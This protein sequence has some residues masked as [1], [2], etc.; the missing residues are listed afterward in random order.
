M[1][2]VYHNESGWIVTYPKRA[3]YRCGF[4][5]PNSILVVGRGPT[6]P[7][8]PDST[9]DQVF[10]VTKLGTEMPLTAVPIKW[11]EPLGLPGGR[12][13]KQAVKPSLAISRQDAWEEKMFNFK[14]LEN[15]FYAKVLVCG[16][17]AGCVGFVIDIVWRSL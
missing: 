2:H 3:I 15:E 1:S 17:L 6:T 11:R 12:K 16:F 10:D 13:L 4:Q 7:D 14:N 5:I 8:D 9:T